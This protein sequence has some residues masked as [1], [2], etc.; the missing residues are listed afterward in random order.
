MYADTEFGGT[1]GLMDVEAVQKTLNRSRASVY[2]YANTD[3]EQLN[4][5]FNPKRLNPELRQS[6]NDPLMFHSN[7]VARFAK[8]VLKIKQVTIE[9]QEPQPN[10]TQEVLEAILVELKSIHELL[11]SRSS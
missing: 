7:E 2:R 9:I 10:H 6:P 8:E 1:T 4:P 11:K 3:L 5:P